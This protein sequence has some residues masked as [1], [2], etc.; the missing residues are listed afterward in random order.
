MVLMFGIL[1]G[2]PNSGGDSTNANAFS[3]YS[4]ATTIVLLAFYAV[5]GIYVQ[6]R[7]RNY[8][9]NTTELSDT[10][11][12]STLSVIEMLGLYLTNGLAIIFSLG[13]LVPWAQIRIAKHRAEHLEVNLG[14]DWQD[15]IA[16]LTEEGSALGEEV[17]EVFDV[18]I[19]VA[20]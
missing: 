13:L 3:L 9:W 17:G 11:F 2:V 8:V 5:I 12:L 7:L 20:F 14:R 15:H 19:D 16:A 1:I 6:V 4:A 10:R 18:D